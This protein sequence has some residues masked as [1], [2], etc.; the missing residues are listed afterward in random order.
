MGILDIIEQR[1]RIENPQVTISSNNVLE[2]MGDRP[3]PAGV[4]I[5]DKRALSLTAF[6]A[7]ERIISQTI[8]DL[9]LQVYERL[10]GDRRRPA[11]E[12]HVNTLLAKRPNAAMTPFTFKELRMSHLLTRGDSYVYIDADGAGKPKALL[13]LLPDRTE[14]KIINGQKW[15][16]TEINGE[17]E[18]LRPDEVCHVP[19]LGFDGLRGYSVIKVFADSL[20]LTYAANE[21]GARL[22]GNSARPSGY[23]SHPDKPNDTERERMK[24]AWQAAHGGLSNAQKTAVLWGGMKFEKISL[25]PEEAQFLQ[26]REFQIEEIARMFNINPILLQHFTKAT[27]WGSGIAQFL[28]A[29]AKFTISPWLKRDE[30]A[31]NWDL[32]TPS[33]RE[34]YYV[35]YNI[36]ALLR[37][38]PETQAKILEIKR[39]N[40]VI[41]ADEWRELDDENPLP[42]GQGKQYFMPLNFMP[43]SA[44]S[45]NQT[46]Y[47]SLSG[48]PD[49][50]N[51]SGAKPTERRS[52]AARQRTR[53]AHKSLFQDGANRY[54]R[55]ESQALIKAVEKAFKDTT[56]ADP[57]AVL[58][59]WID[60]YYPGQQR[61]IRQTMYPIVAALANVIAAESADEVNYELDAD[62]ITKFANEYTETLAAREASSSI[63]QIRS[64]I[65]EETPE[66][67]RDSL[68]TRATEWQETRPEKVAANEVVR[69]ASGA[70]RFAWVS[71][72]V[73][74]MVWRANPG[75]C[76][77]CQEMDG[78]V[79]GTKEY[80]L[81]PG[82]SSSPAG[83][84][85]LVAESNIGG[86]PLHEGCTCDI[87]PQ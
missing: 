4:T 80:F 39:R 86:P 64:L 40:G 28:T 47:P 58:D 61:V 2:L 38:D 3:T 78:R 6:W 13:P 43:I 44:F 51:T 1:S 85:P 32:F 36:N 69:V 16:Q 81:K 30:D 56:Y 84:T 42:D 66:T 49:E 34:H 77:L 21:F 19:G 37:G 70:A 23:L 52:S 74:A 9:P 41:S 54:I 76:P 50:N 82:D 33:E 46:G 83:R 22:F 27:T 73:T 15:Y 25:D 14:P 5:N 11:P 62:E 24:D 57:G 71:A 17:M 79:V 63:G 18:M 26:T 59:R 35:K 31:L 7:A 55:R 53:E 29:F 68:I 65:S 20:G 8:G 60:D 12:H 48:S 72:G 67:L 45:D 87:M 10:P 75:A